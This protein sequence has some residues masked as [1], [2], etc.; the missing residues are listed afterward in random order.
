MTIARAFVDYLEN[1][2]YG[3]FGG[4]IFIGTAPLDAQDT[5]M[6][7]LS[8]GGNNIEKNTSGEKQKNYIISVYYRSTDAQQ[9]DQ[10]L[11]D[12]EELL[13]NK[14]CIDLQGYTVLEVE[15]TLFQSDQDID[16]ED[17]TVGLLQATFTVYQNI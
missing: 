15:T 8:S 4:D 3:S 7:L 16:V 14:D 1:Q 5:I 2:G 10:T 11:Q 13:N 6:W 17:R 9:V 12:L